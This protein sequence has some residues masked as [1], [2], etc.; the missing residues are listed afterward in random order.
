MI[1][2][3]KQLGAWVTELKADP[4]V[5]ARFKLTF[6]K[7]LAVVIFF[8]LAGIILNY[9][10]DYILKTKLTGKLSDLKTEELTLDKTNADI[11]KTDDI[12]LVLLGIATTAVSYILSGVTLEPIRQIVRAQKRFIADASHELRTPLSIMK[13]NSEVALMDGD[14]IDVNESAW[15]L[16]S[17]IEEIDRM[18][19][20]IENLLRLSYYDNKTPEIPFVLV[21]LAEIV[22]SIVNKARTLA[23]KKSI[24]LNVNSADQA[25]ILGNQT[26]LEQ[27]I[28]NIIKN[29]ILYT[30]EGGTVTVSV[31]N[32]NFR[33]VHF[34]VRDTGIGID[35]KEI[36][37]IFNPFY[38]TDASK[39][40]YSG[41]SGLGLTIVKKIVDRHGGQINVESDLGKGTSVTVIFPNL[42]KQKVTQTTQRNVA[43]AT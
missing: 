43:A 19:K 21:D 29:A 32:Y 18:S 39:N 23:F 5:K 35:P 7:I 27:L 16:K 26:A 38:K 6:Q 3:W 20:L 8:V 10:H 40:I 15:V 4:F 25:E 37:N 1:N 12:I 2:Y 28:I 24:R 9:S 22:K 13:T 11:R 17:N 41:G 36:P 14:H 34:N 31:K 33:G 42:Y 30:P